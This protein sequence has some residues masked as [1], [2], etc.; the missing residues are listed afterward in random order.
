MKKNEQENFNIKKALK[1]ALGVL[2][3]FAIFYGLSILITNKDKATYNV[4]TSEE[5]QNKEILI[6]TAFNR[7]DNE[8]LVVFY[9][10]KAN[11]A[12]TNAVVEYR[13]K[14]EHLPTYEV[15]MGNGMNSSYSGASSNR[16]A[17]SLDELQIN[18]TT[19]IRFKEGKIEEYIEGD[20]EVSEYLK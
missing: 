7:K 12:I 18:G 5:I 10:K 3:I 19:L 8:Y 6:G 15:D 1:V 9:N 4:Q 11:N 13:L 16:E 2:I 20:S 17:T 14:E